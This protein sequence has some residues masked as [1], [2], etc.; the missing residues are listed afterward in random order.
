MNL[1]TISTI[2]GALAALFTILGYL[3]K[4]VRFNKARS[5]A[6]QGRIEA[7]VQVVE[8]QGERMTIMEA[9]LSKEDGGNYQVNAGLIKL[10]QKALD[11]Y[12]KHDT[13]L[14]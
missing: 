10:E 13:N 7:L 3:Y 14:T 8:I 11:E 6:Q 1:L 2:L 5:R 9:Y 12:K 4:G